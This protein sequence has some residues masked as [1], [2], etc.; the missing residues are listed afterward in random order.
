MTRV[1]VTGSRDWYARD[2]AVRVVG[3]MVERYGRE[4]LTIVTGGAPGIDLAFDHAA[5]ILNVKREGHPADW[6]NLGRRAGPVRN[7]AMVA[8][9]ADFVLAVHRDLAGS[10]GTR[11]CVAQALAAGLRVY[12]I[13]SDAG[14]PRPMPAPRTG[15][16]ER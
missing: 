2:L 4:N 15:R 3:R 16:A 5:V 14:E 11:D 12:L 1:I 13:D 6:K 7:A 10:K 9:G 8:A